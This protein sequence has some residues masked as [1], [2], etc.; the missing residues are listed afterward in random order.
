[1]GEYKDK[2][3]VSRLHSSA[4]TG[5]FIDGGMQLLAATAPI[6][7]SMRTDTAE[8]M[9]DKG[10]TTHTVNT[11]ANVVSM[12]STGAKVGAM[13][14]PLGAG[15]G[16][17]AGAL[18]GGI[19]SII[20]KNKQPTIGEM[21]ARRNNFNM[22]QMTK[23]I[24]SNDTFVQQQ[25]AAAN[26][27]N[28]VTNTKQI[29]VEKDEIVLRKVGKVFKKI[30]DFKKGKP[31]SMGGEQY[32]AQ[33]GDIIFPGKKRNAVTQA[34][35]LRDWK[36]LES[37]RL[38][39]P[40]DTQNLKKAEGVKEVDPG[41][42]PTLDKM[43]KENRAAWK[44]RYGSDTLYFNEYLNKID[45]TT[46]KPLKDI[47]N[48][49][50]K[51]QNL[52]PNFLFSTLMTEGLETFPF[53][54]KIDSEYQNYLKEG[55]AKPLSKSEFKNEFYGNGSVIGANYF[56]L[57]TIGNVKGEL[58]KKGYLNPEEFKRN[59]KITPFVNEKNESME[60]ADF[61]NLS[62]GID[63]AAAFIRH[64]NDQLDNW[65]TENKTE[66]TPRQKMFF[67]NVAYNAGQGNAQKMIKS[68][69]EKGYLKD[70]SFISTR[71]DESW[72]AVHTNASR[73]IGSMVGLDEQNIL[74][75]NT[76]MKRK[77]EIPVS[78]L[79]TNTFLN[80][81]KGVESIKGLE[82]I[83]QYAKGTSE[84]VIDKNKPKETYGKNAL[85]IKNYIYNKL[86]EAGL[87]ENA[88]KGL[89]VNLAYETDNFTAL[90][91]R[92]TNVYGTKGLGIAQW[93]DSPS[94][95]RRTAFEKFLKDKG[96]EVS[97]ID[98]NIEFLL[99][100]LKEEQDYKLGVTIESF[101]KNSD[102]VE[103]ASKY[104]LTKFERPNNQSD[105]HNTKRIAASKEFLQQKKIEPIPIQDPNIGKNS[106]LRPDTENVF[107]TK[108]LI[109]EYLSGGAS[110]EQIQFEKDLK[111]GKLPYWNPQ[112]GTGKKVREYK[113]NRAK[114]Y[115]NP[116][117]MENKW[118]EP[119]GWVSSSAN[120]WVKTQ[121]SDI[122][123]GL[124]IT[125]RVTGKEEPGL[126]N[127]PRDSKG[128]L[129]LNEIGFE[130][131][132]RGKLLEEE[133]SNFLN[134][135]M[136]TRGVGN[137][138][139]SA[140][141]GF[142]A[143]R[144]KLLT[145]QNPAAT[146]PNSIGNLMSWYEP[147]EV[148]KILKELKG[149]D[150][151]SP[152][153]EH[154]VRDA[155]NNPENWYSKDTETGFKVDIATILA[156][157]KGVY[158][159]AKTGVTLAKTG[160]KGVIKAPQAL[161]KVLSKENLKSSPALAKKAYKFIKNAFEDG[162]LYFKDGE[163]LE[164][165]TKIEK[166]AVASGVPLDKETSTFIKAMSS[167]RNFIVSLPDKMRKSITGTS[168]KEI[169]EFQKTA[170]NI[171][172]KTTSELVKMNKEE[173]L[174]L[175][176]NA[177][178][179]KIDAITEATKNKEAAWTKYKDLKKSFDNLLKEEKAVKAG[180]AS[181]IEI[182]RI[183]GQIAERTKDLQAVQDDL[184]KIAATEKQAYS[185]VSRLEA[186]MDDDLYKDKWRVVKQL[187]DGVNN[188]IKVLDDSDE[189]KSLFKAD[190]DAISSNLKALNS[191]LGE[192]RKA[193]ILKIR[194]AG[195][196]VEDAKT[197][198]R[199]ATGK[200]SPLGHPAKDLKALEE[201]FKDFPAVWNVI[202]KDA[203]LVDQLFSG[204]KTAAQV[205]LALEH[206]LRDAPDEKLK[207][208]LNKIKEDP[209]VIPEDIPEDP[210]LEGR[211]E[212]QAMPDELKPGLNIKGITPELELTVP[213][214]IQE[215]KKAKI[216]DVDK[217]AGFLSK[218]GGGLESL[219]AYAPAIYNIVK[220]LEDPEKV[221]RRFVTPQTREYKN[222][223]Q[224]QLNLIDEA[225]EQQL[226]NARNLSGGQMSNFRSNSEKAWADKISRTGQ[227]NMYE[228]GRA[229]Q[230]A[231]EN[232]QIRNNAEQINTNTNQQADVMDMQSK[233]AT[234]S[235]LAQG[236]QDVANIS[237]V[238]SRDRAEKETQNT[239]LKMM[240]TGD[241][242]YDINSNTIKLK[243][244]P[245]IKSP[246]P[247]TMEV[248]IVQ[249]SKIGQ[250][251]ENF[252]DINIISNGLYKK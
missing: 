188:Q 114:M 244:T 105:S 151:L 237:T 238:N 78:T 111:A 178:A 218:I 1:M 133:L 86:L 36:R 101:N 252:L 44:E 62:S 160:V 85:D 172:G 184:A 169:K 157:P 214:E 10:A 53:Q 112:T 12:A 90:E 224:A 154:I 161:L 211:N 209:T 99:S 70:E 215:G 26:G 98:A 150:R 156:N 216:G 95:K 92:G 181:P 77:E 217:G 122:I 41:K 121:V 164:N 210:K 3:G 18:A 38:Q 14:G 162:T 43:T 144:D 250:A 6:V 142:N 52:D 39:L 64:S 194:N 225:F 175:Y 213:T 202:K 182:G 107:T 69:G 48:S 60:S 166:N 42:I 34:L 137:L 201:K 248:P 233:A 113:E 59:A 191:D 192:A 163:T 131:S 40:S 126:K 45:P 190:Q 110:A 75:F 74:K 19:M 116:E 115:K 197:A 125:E 243:S 67:Q 100:E 203:K 22:Q 8:R 195:M 227:V 153:A 226:G 187:N 35:R 231:G 2:N 220:G 89:V 33:E 79:K 138:V 129:I 25:Q 205:A 223:S 207:V 108:S 11:G 104:T 196:E 145:G 81:T 222:I 20:D 73:R 152:W 47:I 87:N 103:A 199:I 16:A 96:A 232:I 149:S 183:E 136:G 124:N 127:L 236:I 83:P 5:D 118:Y 212:K 32:M 171:T 24:A 147:A 128:K 239:M 56:G 84:V 249:T 251:P 23:S 134:Y 193:S 4:S 204:G 31:H 94:T 17:G 139:L 102:T 51:K 219:A 15:I 91:E 54:D 27:L 200:A 168:F 120:K 155:Y 72:K 159:L 148:E 68:Y 247:T 246:K 165:L 119:L 146:L 82:E 29:E 240:S 37:M 176:N 109:P 229:D 234:N 208:E 66:L 30:A 123:T 46:G 245:E 135:T 93:T 117:A 189:L 242:E 206:K 97:D 180:N 61:H 58:F 170:E 130:N 230:I 140:A 235:F 71:P 21:T 57:D 49:I 106:V 80:S 65:A 76:P 143:Y 173:V 88:A 167:T 228:S 177:R 174:Q 7:K 221:T 55:H 63:A 141:D 198:A 179:S 9:N 50:A 158:N 241:Y 132:R 185:E 186:F 13:F 28:D